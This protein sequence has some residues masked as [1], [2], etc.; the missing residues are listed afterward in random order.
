[1][2]EKSSKK[3]LAKLHTIWGRLSPPQSESGRN[4][5][6]LELLITQAYRNLEKGVSN[7]QSGSKNVETADLNDRLSELTDSNNSFI[8]DQFST[9]HKLSALG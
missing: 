1:M 6:M 8:S 2:G 7:T 4:S 3:Y 9:P 5:R